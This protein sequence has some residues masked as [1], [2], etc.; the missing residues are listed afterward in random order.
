MKVLRPSD[1]VLSA[2]TGASL[3]RVTLTKVPHA[4]RPT[5]PY[6]GCDICGQ[7]PGAYQH[8]PCAKPEDFVS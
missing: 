1:E 4:Y 6:R 5:D 2:L 8:N 7:G 3:A